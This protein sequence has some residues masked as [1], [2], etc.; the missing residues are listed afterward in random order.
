M[1]ISHKLIAI[2]GSEHVLER[3]RIKLLD[4]GL[5]AQNL[6]CD[7]YVRPRNAEETAGLLKLCSE[8]GQPV[9]A[10][11]G[12][13][14]GSGGARSRARDIVVAT[15]RMK[16][17]EIDDFERVAV[18]GAGCTLGEVQD[19]CA[20]HGLSPGIDIGARGTATIGGMISTNAGGMETWRNGMM[21][22][23]IL[24]LE[25]ALANGDVITDM[26]RVKKA[27]EGY[28]LKQL[29]CG[30]E[31]TLGI[32]TQAVLRLEVL[33]P[34]SETIL[35][36]LKSTS[37]AI[38]AMR[39]LQDA[40]HLQLAEVMWREFAQDN[41]NVLGLSH[42]NDLGDA[43][44][45]VIYQVSGG[46]D[47][48]LAVLEPLMQDGSILDAIV[49][50]SEREQDE[51]WRVREDSAA[52]ERQHP[53]SLWFDISVPLSHI[54]SYLTRLTRHLNN[55]NFVT[56]TY[57]LGHLADGNLHI[58]VTFQVASPE[59]KRQVQLLVESGLKDIG[60]SISA[61]HGIGESKLS[62]LQRATSAA[63]LAIMKSLKNV[64]DPAGILNQGKVIPDERR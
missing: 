2:L 9:V 32:V 50:K 31:G 51:I 10:Q 63:P 45:Y 55:L 57:V 27:N 52:F 29:F 60:G 59:E 20:R 6:G 42:I 48:V 16:S 49:A 14:G 17:I 34:P 28:D 13:T 36:A 18:V 62:A 46:I 8:L 22:D 11:G 30:A 64:F 19:A 53:S 21:R 43:P 54:D 38:S 40:G 47:D 39:A 24:G 23:R 4:H 26:T 33:P 35:A 61:E 5:D 44:L 7:L 37:A 56:G 25:V 1:D 12:R 58:L 3:D 15:D 41:A